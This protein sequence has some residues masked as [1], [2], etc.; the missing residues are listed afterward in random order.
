MGVTGLLQQLKDIQEKSSLSQYKGQTLAVDTYGWLH[1]G[2]IL[3]AQ[4]LC[5][6]APTR[7]YVTSVM[8]KVDMLRHFGVEPYMVFDG[9]LL[10]TKESTNNE[11][12]LKREKAQETA[13]KMVQR[14]DRK[15]AWK[16]FMKAA[17]VTPEMAKSVMLELDRKHVKYVVAPYEADPQMVYLEKTGVVD[18]ILSEDLD[19]L[20]FGCRR[21]ITKLNDYGECIEINTDNLHKVPRLALHTFTPAQWR[22]V[23]ILSG[24][25]YTKGIPGVGLK[26]AFNLVTKLQSLDKIVLALKADNK[27][28]PDEFMED[29]LKADLAFQYQK[30]FDPRKAVVTTLCDV[31]DPTIDLDAL[32]SC[33]GCF[34]DAQIQQGI[35]TGN[36]HPR[37]Y[38]ALI[39]REQ[40]LVAKK[41]HSIANFSASTLSAFTKTVKASTVTKTLQSFTSSKSIESYFAKDI[42]VNKPT[43]EAPRAEREKETKLSPSSRKLKRIALASTAKLTKSKFFLLHGDLPSAKATAQPT[44][45]DASFLTGDSEVPDYSSSPVRP[46][47]A[48]PTNYLTDDDETYDNDDQAANSI[49]SSVAASTTT[50]L[51]SESDEGYEDEIDESPVKLL[52]IG[53]SWRQ[54]FSAG[55]SDAPPAK[56]H[57]SSRLHRGKNLR[58]SDHTESSL[59]PAT[60]EDTEDAPAI[61]TQKSLQIEYLTGDDSEDVTSQIK[62]VSAFTK[63]LSFAFR[64]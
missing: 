17:A 8:K 52:N 9:L 29:A 56:I 49:V 50:T 40:F 63:L 43:L 25:D 34:L 58:Q 46:E 64:G 30:V 5:T 47:T 12:R 20:V 51:K 14:G 38:D 4:D 3:C 55:A 41:S 6:D 39:S 62:P 15:S 35:C 60:P 16:E 1:R 18:G 11:R 23:A 24:C 7:G 28:V 26:T 19:L 44:E 59:G 32:E 53:L 45:A 42:Q 22:L 36:L 10:P 54:K 31:V 33:C 2:L 37:T 48:G 57:K 21:L 13:A 27:Q 61:T